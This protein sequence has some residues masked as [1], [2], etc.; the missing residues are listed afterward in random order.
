[1]FCSILVETGSFTTVTVG[2]L[3][4]GHTHA[5]IDQ[6][7]SCLRKKIRKAAFIATP[8]ALQY[9]FSIPPSTMDNLR[10]AFRPPITQIQ[11][12]FVHDYKAALAPYF[13]KSI[14]NY[15]IPY[16]FRFSLVLGKCIC[17]TK[18]FSDRNLEWLPR[19]PPGVEKSIENILRARIVQIPSTH[20][21]TT[22][23]GRRNLNCFLGLPH[24]I[25]PASIAGSSRKNQLALL[26]DIEE[27]LP[28]LEKMEVNA[29]AEQLLR[30]YDE[31][32]G[33]DGQERYRDINDRDER[34]SLIKTQQSLQSVNNNTSG[35]NQL[36]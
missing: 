4:I 22:E 25:E 32:E 24:I 1:M 6:Y 28:H 9:L 12:L 36:K 29:N 20:N 2:F 31:S 27:M 18:M 7:F 21:L 3:I 17:Q 11:L 19:K 5:S 10:S 30:H 13:N 34:D 15:N 23:E 35:I 26:A 16:Q 33:L 14:T 8:V